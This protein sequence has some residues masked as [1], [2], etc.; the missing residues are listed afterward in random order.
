[1]IHPSPT[2]WLPLAPDLPRLVF[3][4][5]VKSA[6]LALTSTREL[7]RCLRSC[8]DFQGALQQRLHLIWVCS[9]RGVPPSLLG[10]MGVACEAGANDFWHSP[11]GDEHGYL[12]KSTSSG[13]MGQG[14]VIRSHSKQGEQDDFGFLRGHQHLSSTVAKV[15]RPQSLSSPFHDMGANHRCAFPGGRPFVSTCG[16]FKHENS[17]PHSA[18]KP[19]SKQAQQT[20]PQ[21]GA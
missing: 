3:S 7:S 20:R 4:G 16:G 6:A 17:F 8:P 19:I 10:A 9:M 2:C 14:G 1:M 15:G 11:E 13:H 12:Y 5:G 21:R 18:G